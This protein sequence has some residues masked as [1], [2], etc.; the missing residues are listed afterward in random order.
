MHQSQQQPIA[1]EGGD[2]TIPITTFDAVAANEEDEEKYVNHLIST[3]GKRE[4]HRILQQEGIE[5]VRKRLAELDAN[6]PPYAV[7]TAAEEEDAQKNSL[8]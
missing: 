1:C 6:L 4:W 5:G 3:R 7:A 8:A 2:I